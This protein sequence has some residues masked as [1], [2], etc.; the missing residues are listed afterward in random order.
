M[1]CSRA[2]RMAVATSERDV[3]RTITAGRRSCTAFHSRR[4]SSYVSSAGVTMSPAKASRRRCIWS[5]FSPMDD[6]TIVIPVALSIEIECRRLP[7]PSLVRVVT[8]VSR[9]TRARRRDRV[10]SVSSAG[11]AAG[12]CRSAGSHRG[13]VSRIPSPIDRPGSWCCSSRTRATGRTA[14]ARVSPLAE[15]CPVTR[16]PRRPRAARTPC[17]V[18]D[19]I[20]RAR[21]ES[22]SQTHVPARS[23]AV[24]RTSCVSR[25]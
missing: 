15:N 5:L 19:G 7:R 17:A 24:I 16:P 1:S 18:D 14:E 10:G 3:G 6:W 12:R 4:A 11:A 13:G 22:G 21:S 23:S 20:S 2:K 8:R 9:A 25:R